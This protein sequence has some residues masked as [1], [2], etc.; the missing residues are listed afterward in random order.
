[1]KEFQS[2]TGLYAKTKASVQVFFMLAAL[3]LLAGCGG[4]GMGMGMGAPWGHGNAGV[5]TKDARQ[6]PNVAWQTAGDRRDLT[7]QD[8]AFVKQGAP[9]GLPARAEKVRVAL[10]LPL[11][12]KNADLGQSMLKAAQMALFDVGSAN[13]DLVPRDTHSTPEGAAA[14]AQAAAQAGNDLIL[15][16]IFAEDVRVVRPIAQGARIPVIAFTTD[17]SLGGNGTYIMGFLPFAQVARVAQFAQSHGHDRIAAFAPSTEYCD[18]VISTLQRTGGLV[19]TARYSPQQPDLSGIVADFVS[20]ARTSPTTLE[21]NALM[22]PVGGESLR[23]LMALLDLQGVNGGTVRLLGTGLWDDPS[24]T[25]D[26]ALFG[27]WFAAPDPGTRQDF[28]RRYQENYG[29]AP[30]RLAS[31]AYDATALSAVL[32]RVGGAQPYAAANLM[33]PRGFAG[34]DGLFRFR[35]DGLAERGLAVL[36]IRSGRA[37]VVDPAPTAFAGAGS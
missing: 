4:G 22:L 37:A 6:L 28:D 16:P 8:Q 9:A 24:L 33:N 1:L 14:A 27:G 19:R 15:G 5:V 17:W 31:L 21:F 7:A 26:P 32:A 35:G 23:S 3:L 20:S 18:T 25:R 29:A 12:G 11:T 10:L 36:E 13:Y 2:V 34:I 30:P